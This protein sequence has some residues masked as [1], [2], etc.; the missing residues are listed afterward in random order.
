[1]PCIVC[2]PKHE[3]HKSELKEK[4]DMNEWIKIN[5]ELM[6]TKNELKVNNDIKQKLI[7]KSG[8]DPIYKKALELLNEYENLFDDYKIKSGIKRKRSVV[9]VDELIEKVKLRTGK[10]QVQIEEISKKLLK[11]LERVKE[12]EKAMNEIDLNKEEEQLIQLKQYIN[13]FDFERFESINDSSAR[14]IKN[15]NT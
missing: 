10:L 14:A 7:E 8:L 15:L 5:N 12:A 6:K 4:M 9:S 11:K 3:I 2:E 1:M 13:N